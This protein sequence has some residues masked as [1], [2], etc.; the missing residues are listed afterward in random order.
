MGDVAEQST[1]GVCE[2]FLVQPVSW[3][4][5]VPLVWGALCWPMAIGF[6]F[7]AILQLHYEARV[8]TLQPL[9]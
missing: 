3:R 8:D 6:A 7:P 9:S 4:R 1:I 5:L 2:I